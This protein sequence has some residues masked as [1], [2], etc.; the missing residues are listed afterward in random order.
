MQV[1]ISSILSLKKILSVYEKPKSIQFFKNISLLHALDIINV[2]FIVY[3]NCKNNQEMQFNLNQ[4][5]NEI[6]LLS[7]SIEIIFTDQIIKTSGKKI[8]EIKID[9]ICSIYVEF[10]VI[11][12]QTYKS[13]R[14]F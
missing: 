11:M 2:L 10:K 1:I 7:K 13:K 3:I 9:E 14:F 12:N 5:K 8:F 4:V 6:L